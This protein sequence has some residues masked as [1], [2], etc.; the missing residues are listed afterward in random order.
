MKKGFDTLI[1]DT[2]GRLHIDEEMVQELVRQKKLLTPEGD[3]PR[4]RRH[5]RAGR[6]EHGEGLR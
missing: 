1:V 2:A 3:A 5:D 4:R 6:G